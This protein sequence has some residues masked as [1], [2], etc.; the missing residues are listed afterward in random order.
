MLGLINTASISTGI[1]FCVQKSLQEND[2]SIEAN[3]EPQKNKFSFSLFLQG[4]IDGLFFPF[5][6]SL[7]GIEFKDFFL[8]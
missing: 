3:N 8:L 2:F 1:S 6:F 5:N 7:P 4:Y